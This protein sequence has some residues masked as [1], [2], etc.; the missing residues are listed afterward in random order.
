MLLW[1]G[2]HGDYKDMKTLPPGPCVHI[3]SRL[4]SDKKYSE[5]VE[6]A[7]AMSEKVANATSVLFEI[8]YSYGECGNPVM[9]R[10]C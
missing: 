1:S 8:A 3:I 5:I 6:I 7:D 2:L 10:Q 9:A 4:F